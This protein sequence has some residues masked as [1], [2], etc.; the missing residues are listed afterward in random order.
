MFAMV[1]LLTL[2][3][4]AL[5]GDKTRAAIGGGAGGAI[6]AAVG[7]ELGDRQGAIIGGAVGGAI[8]AA[9]ATD[10][11][12]SEAVRVIEVQPVLVEPDRPRGQFCPPGLAKQGRC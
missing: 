6:G 3:S 10:E 7:E 11:R 8:G 1:L 12:E 5:A 4:T 9:I 2:N